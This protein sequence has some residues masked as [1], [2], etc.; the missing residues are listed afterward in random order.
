MSIARMPI[1][2]PLFDPLEARVLLEGSPFPT[3]QMLEDPGDAVIRLSSAYG[4]VDIELFHSAA[5]NTTATF[6]S[7]LNSGA[8]T[9]TFFHSLEGGVRL[10]AGVDRFSNADGLSAR[11]GLFPADAP[12]TRA[13]LERTV[14]MPVV[15]PNGTPETTG[16]FVF[17]L[18]DNSGSDG[19]YAV[20]GKVI[21][22]WSV[23]LQIAAL[24]VLDLSGFFPGN[25][26]G[27]A[28]THVPV[29]NDGSTPP[30]VTE[31]LLVPIGEM[32]AIKPRGTPAFYTE[33][34]Y[35]PDGYS[36]ERTFES[37]ELLNPGTEASSFQILVRY[38]HGPRDQVVSTG[39]V[40]AQERQSVVISPGFGH[41]SSIVRNFEPYGYEV[42]STS[43]IVAGFRH[44]DFKAGVGE[45]FFRP[46]SLPDQAAM[47]EWSFVQAARSTEDSRI[48]LLWLNTTGSDAT[49]TVTFYFADADPI[50]QT[51]SLG[52][53]RRGG[54]NLFDITDRDDSPHHHATY[55][56]A[57]V[58]ADQDIVASMSRYDQHTESEDDGG[59]DRGGLATL[60]TPGGG[61][62][63][64][65]TPGAARGPDTPLAV[66]NTGDT[67]ATVTFTVIQEGD[68]TSTNQ[69]VH[70]PAGRLVVLSG[71]GSPASL[72]SHGQFF[73]LRYSA[74]H[75]VT[76]GF[77]PLPGKSTGTPSAIFAA[78]TTHFADA[79]VFTAPRGGPFGQQSLSLFN[80][81]D[82]DAHVTITFS[83]AGAAPVSAP[84][85]TLGAGAATHRK[86]TEFASL[87]AQWLG[88]VTPRTPYSLT[89]ESDA[90]IVAQTTQLN[91]DGR[92]ELGMTL[93]QWVPLASLGVS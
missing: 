34:L 52:A 84:G 44:K 72:A 59:G 74:D 20:F 35:F 22:G 75:P 9:G 3:L 83:F 39:E 56:G 71:S 33:R 51:F 18:G 90:P 92:A 17:N 86:I 23:V 80:P 46:A 62:A 65:V 10:S 24:P 29:T 55:I 16:E 85:F 4:D 69:V 61:A 67:E 11:D 57:R 64:G 2:G 5:P 31:D 12:P 79:R 91:S 48:F 76:V 58:T 21:Q 7:L 45:S 43:P 63:V 38:E 47:R 32:Q 49:V 25:P 42:W 14:A 73:S 40:A 78:L 1:A 6:L 93:G 19:G 41:K 53:H 81:G 54:A 87:I 13:N 26:A 36:W 82:T 60:G 50:Q 68:G 27:A 28:L 77:V 8:Y 15:T 66:L 70:V 30:A 88:G 37:I 89:I